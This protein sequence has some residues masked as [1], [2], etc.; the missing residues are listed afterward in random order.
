MCRLPWKGHVEWVEDIGA[1]FLGTFTTDTSGQLDVFWHDGDTLGVD[2]AQVGVFEQSDQVGFTGFL[3]SHDSWALEPQV[4]LEILGDLSHE[5]LEWQFPDEELGALLVSPDFTK[6]DCSRP[7]SVWFLDSTGGWCRLASSF[8][9]QLFTW[10][11]ASS[12]FTCGLLGTSHVVSWTATDWVMP[13]PA[14]RAAFIP[15]LAGNRARQALRLARLEILHADWLSRQTSVGLLAGR[16]RLTEKCNPAYLPLVRGR[17][18]AT[19][20]KGK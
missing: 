19:N 7:V 12:R 5:T 3:Q 11:L 9:G 17:P 15:V 13:G 2:G 4:G 6:G 1:C 10:G 20:V 14:A 18:A 16:V 8:G